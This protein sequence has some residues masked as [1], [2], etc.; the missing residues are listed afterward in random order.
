M[1]VVLF[2]IAPKINTQLRYFCQKFCYLEVHKV[3]QSGHKPRVTTTKAIF[4]LFN[5]ERKND[6]TFS[7]TRSPRTIANSKA[8]KFLS[9]NLAGHLDTQHQC[10]QIWQN[11]ATLAKYQVFGSF[12]EGLFSIQLNVGHILAIFYSSGH[13]L[14][15]QMAKY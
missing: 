14:G 9:T 11:F 12:V 3:A 8:E 10:D 15:L 7:R 6:L 5:H 13:I 1:K 2:K 4:L